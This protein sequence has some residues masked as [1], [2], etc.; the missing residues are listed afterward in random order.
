VRQHPECC[1]SISEAVM[2][3]STYQYQQPVILLRAA[4]ERRAQADTE[5]IGTVWEEPVAVGVQDT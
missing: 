4:N 3:S 2:L 5:A 1:A